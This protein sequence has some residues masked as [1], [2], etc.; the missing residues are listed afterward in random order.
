M[1]NIIQMLILMMVHHSTIAVYGCTN[2]DYVEYNANA[3]VDDG[4][5]A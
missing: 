2:S 5:V 1:L 4:S 3:N